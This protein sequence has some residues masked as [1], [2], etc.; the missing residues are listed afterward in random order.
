MKEE[1]VLHIGAHKTGTTTIQRALALY[2]EQLSKKNVH[3]A[4]TGDHN[5]VHQSLGPVEYQKLIPKGFRVYK[6]DDLVQNLTNH[7]M[8]RVIASSENFSFFFAEDSINR[9]AQRINPFFNKVTILTYLRRQD[10]HAVSHYQE[11]AKPDR[12][13]EEQLYGY[14]PTPLPMRSNVLD[15]YL[16]YNQRIGMWADVFGEENIIVRPFE[17]DQL[18]GSDIWLDFL[19]TLSIEPEGM[20]DHPLLNASMGK[21]RTFLGHI[22][23]EM[24]LPSS[25]KQILLDLTEEDK[26]YLPCRRDAEAFYSPYKESNQKL[27]ERLRVNGTYG[28][29]SERFEEYPESEVNLW[30]EKSVEQLTRTLVQFIANM[31]D[32]NSYTAKISE[33]EH[34]RDVA[35]KQRDH[36]RRHP[37]K[38]FGYALKSRKKKLAGPRRF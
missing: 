29:F 17:R 38:Y 9:L 21:S 13:A 34:E 1:L 19:K 4:T 11:G 23:N 10:A 31:R 18:E 12:L 32:N 5:N 27:N 22:M 26:K 30:T 3:F 7:D 6:I 2:R 36:A 25:T 20:I 33:L 15:F 16:D 8:D 37:W 28:I 35:C 24:G 14:R